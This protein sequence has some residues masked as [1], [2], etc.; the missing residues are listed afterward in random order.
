MFQVFADYNQL[1]MRPKIKGTIAQYQSQLLNQ[2]HKD[3]DIL[4][5]KLLNQDKIDKTLIFARDIPDVSNKIV[6]MNQIES[7][8]K[9]YQDRVS[10]ILGD[11]WKAQ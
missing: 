4:K 1:L 7:K 10:K 5:T 2:V 11:D 6:W 3:I 8:L 9:F